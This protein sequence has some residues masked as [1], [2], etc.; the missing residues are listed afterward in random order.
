MAVAGKNAVIELGANTIQGLND[1]KITVNGN[2]IDVTTFASGGWI[3]KIQGLKDCKISMS[4]FYL[5]DDTNG[6]TALQ[7]ALL[8]GSPVTLKSLLDGT[9][10]WT[11][12]FLVA[13]F[14]DEAKVAGEVTRSIN[15]ESTGALTTV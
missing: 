9:T 14:D 2:T 12:S 3:E 11:G 13:S 4:G 5:S 1:T 15:L 10:G 7:T 8:N 6:Q